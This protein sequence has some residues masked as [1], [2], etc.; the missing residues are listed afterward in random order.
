MKSDT[1][2]YFRERNFQ[3]GDMLQDMLSFWILLIKVDEG[4]VTTLEGHPRNENL[5]LRKRSLDDFVQ[6]CSYKS[7]NGYWVDYF[8]T[9]MDYYDDFVYTYFKQIGE[10]S[11]DRDRILD[12]IIFDL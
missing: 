8:G 1:E 6:H 11:H 10:R 9:S 5:S 2:R 3:V 7:I 12:K 4:Y